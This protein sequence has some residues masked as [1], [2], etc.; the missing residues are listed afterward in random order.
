MH[1]RCRGLFVADSFAWIDGITRTLPFVSSDPGAR[2]TE[3]Q[4]TNRANHAVPD[5]RLLFLAFVRPKD[6]DDIDPRIPY[7]SGR[8]WVG[9]T[10][11]G[12][13]DERGTRRLVKSLVDDA[14]GA[15]PALEM[16]YEP[17]TE[18]GGIYAISDSS[19]PTDAQV[20]FLTPAGTVMRSMSLTPDDGAR[21]KGAVLESGD[22]IV[23]SWRGA[24]DNVSAEPS[25]SGPVTVR[26]DSVLEVHVDWADGNCRVA[27]SATGDV[28][29]P[30]DVA[31][32]RCGSAFFY[33]LPRRHRRTNWID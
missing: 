16:R 23:E 19:A 10:L 30:A 20:A 6:F 9:R 28:T 18:P 27:I 4:A 32:G 22:Y 17:G 26:S 7:G 13:A 25:C 15:S 31:A 12:P 11:I 24:T 8:T 2:L 33:T 1:E 29:P 14:T 21:G 3:E 5:G